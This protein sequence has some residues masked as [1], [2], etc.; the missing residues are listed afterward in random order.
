MAA[1]LCQAVP[2]FRSD[3]KSK[4]L[5]ISLSNEF[6]KKYIVTEIIACLLT[7]FSVPWEVANF[8]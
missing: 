7:I 2:S 4:S 1:A 5:F 8:I 3:Y 6:Y